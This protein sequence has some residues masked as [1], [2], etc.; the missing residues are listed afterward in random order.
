MELEEKADNHLEVCQRL[1]IPAYKVGQKVRLNPR[2]LAFG[3]VNKEH[4]EK[5]F[6]ISKV[7]LT[8]EEKKE[9]WYELKEF[10]GAVCPVHWI[11]P[12]EI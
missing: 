12:D 10:L 11:M 1:G 7:V 5:V 9:Y 3:K 4:L 8:S 2:L 6:T